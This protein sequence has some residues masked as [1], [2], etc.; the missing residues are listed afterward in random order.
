MAFDPASGIHFEVLGQGPAVMVA[1]PLMA[2]YREIFGDA[3]MPVF[4]GYV[5]PLKD[6]FSLILI[7]YPSIGQS[8]DIAPED[9]TA[10]RVCADLL[11]VATAAGHDR[12]AYWGYSWSGA[13]GLQLAA[14]TDRLSALV[15]GGWPPLG[16]PY[17][18]LLDASRRK[19]GHVE[20]GSR[21]ILRSDDQYRQ[22]SCY[23]QSMIDWDEASS[24]AAIGC[25]RFGYFGGNGDLVEAGLAV[26]IASAFRANRARLEAMGWDIVEFSGRGHDV[27]MDATLVVPPV[28]AF[29]DR[30]LG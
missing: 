5:G 27:C 20:P 3:M 30:A 8:R 29:L 18:N 14:R 23:Y 19:I 9:L 6:R 24:V 2:S 11:R 22:W 25:P 10:D 17:A 16:G 13:V 12:F 26:N 1:L 7:D 4:N 21:I 28:A 15:I